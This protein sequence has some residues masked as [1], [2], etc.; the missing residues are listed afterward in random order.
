MS[1]LRRQ[2]NAN[3]P[4]VVETKHLLDIKATTGNLYESIPSLQEEQTRSTF[5]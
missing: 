4:S 5:L 1:K 3:T 2:I